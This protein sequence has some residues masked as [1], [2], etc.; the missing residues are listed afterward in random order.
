MKW[1]LK[2]AVILFVGSLPAQT[3]VAIPETLDLP[4]ALSYALENNFAIRQ[5]ERVTVLP[6]SSHP[7]P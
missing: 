4:T 3:P 5:A 1:I 7:V 2:I 6:Q